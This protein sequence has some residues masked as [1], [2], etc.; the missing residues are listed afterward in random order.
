MGF[1]DN[2]IKNT[3]SAHKSNSPMA[4]SLRRSSCHS[5]INFSLHRTKTFPSHPLLDF[6][7]IKLSFSPY[8]VERRSSQDV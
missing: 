4:S 3:A 5:I 8:A 7:F 2:E 1:C 6:F